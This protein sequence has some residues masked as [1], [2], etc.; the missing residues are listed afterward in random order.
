M[1][2]PG[3]V[4][5]CA[6]ADMVPFTDRWPGNPDSRDRTLAYWIEKSESDEWSFTQL[7][8]L[9]GQIVDTGGDIPDALQR[10]ANEVASNRR[11][12]QKRT[13]PKGNRTRDAWI[14]AFVD[15]ATEAGLSQRA[16]AQYIGRVLGMSAEAVVSARRRGLRV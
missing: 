14:A 16:A 11:K 6:W 8:Q 5:S 4:A 15:I 7:Q 12:L 13:G 2:D 3:A 1:V 10:W 9:L